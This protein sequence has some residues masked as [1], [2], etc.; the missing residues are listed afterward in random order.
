M[1]SSRELALYF[2]QFLCSVCFDH[3]IG[4]FDYSVGRSMLSRYHGAHRQRRRAFSDGKFFFARSIHW[5]KK[6]I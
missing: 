4:V 6:Q 5:I 3:F 2:L 1:A